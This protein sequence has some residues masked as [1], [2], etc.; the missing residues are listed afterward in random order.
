MKANFIFPRYSPK[1]PRE[2]VSSL[3]KVAHLQIVFNAPARRREKISIIIEILRI[4]FRGCSFFYYA[5]KPKENDEI[6]FS[7]TRRRKEN[8]E[9]FTDI[10]VFPNY[11]DIV[12]EREKTRTSISAQTWAKL[13][14]CKKNQWRR[15]HT[16]K[17]C[18]RCNLAPAKNH[19][20]QICAHL[21]T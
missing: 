14:S 10:N 9:K 8:A 6:F 19:T 4:N 11:T 1:I 16:K 3:P 13:C 17:R 15:Q 2:A 5:N 18:R 21:L 20:G 12:I 7:P